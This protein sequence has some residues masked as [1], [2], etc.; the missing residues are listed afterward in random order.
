MEKLAEFFE[1]LA[2]RVRPIRHLVIASAILSYFA[3]RYF[4][5]IEQKLIPFLLFTATL[6]LAGLFF[7]YSSHYPLHKGYVNGEEISLS[8]FRKSG[9]SF[10]V[11]SLLFFTFWFVF[12]A[13]FTLIL[14]FKA[15]S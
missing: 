6:W 4:E 9:E 8:K 5:D 1:W 13:V 2:Q 12:L 7:V 14:I 15:S 3:S 11:Y 10:Q